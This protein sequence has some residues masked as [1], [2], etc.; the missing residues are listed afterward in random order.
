MIR[1]IMLREEKEKSGC[2]LVFVC[3][4]RKSIELK[5]GLSGC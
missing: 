3:E 4:K 2:V 5:S 1:L